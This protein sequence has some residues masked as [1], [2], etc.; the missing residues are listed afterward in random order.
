LRVSRLKSEELKIDNAISRERDPNEG[1]FERSWES[2]GPM[3]WCADVRNRDAPAPIMKSA[4]G[5]ELRLAEM[6]QIDH[7][8]GQSFECVMQL[9][10]SF[11]AQQQAAELV[12]P[13]EHPLDGMESLFENG[14]IE[15]GLAAPL[16]DF[17]TTGVRVDVGDHAAIEDGFAIHPTIVDAIQADNG[18]FQSQA[19]GLGDSRHLRQGL[20]QQSGLIPITRGRNQRCD[21]VAISITEGDDFIAFYLLVAAEPNVVAALLRRRGGTVAMDD[22]DVQMIV[23]LQRHHR[24][25]ENGVKATVRLPPSKSA[26]NAR[27]VDFGTTLLI[28]FYGQLLPLTPKVKRLQDVV[29]DRVRGQLGCWSSAPN[30][31]MRQ[32]KLLELLKTQ[33][34]WNMLPLR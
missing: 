19:D 20:S 18:S 6:P 13:A 7:R 30:R 16:G 12:F 17:S 23:F 4:L 8:I 15:K 3:G 14:P 22:A 9:A 33:M 32:D 2:S 26:V 5:G 21:Y 34:C 10:E 24:P 27:V 1:P 31:K 29:E 25:D 28:L 11:K